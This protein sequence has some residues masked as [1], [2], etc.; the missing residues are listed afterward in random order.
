MAVKVGFI[1]FGEV[2]SIFSK[3]MRENG[4]DVAAYDILLTRSG[5]R[6]TLSNRVRA[7][8]I[9]FGSL[10]EVIAHA[11]YVL[12]TVTTQVAR[13]AAKECTALLRP[14]QILVDLN[15]TAP[16]IKVEIGE[17]LKAAGIDFVEGA[18][19]GAV[20]ATGIKTRILTGGEK[21][22]EVAE[23]FTRFGL[24][25]S[26]YDPQIGKA[27]MFKMLRSIFSKGLEALIIELLVAGKRAGI[28]KDLWKDVSEFMTRNPFEQVA[29]NWVQSHAVAHERRYFEIVQVRE[30]MEEIRIEPVMTSGTEAFFKRSI[31][32]G[33]K[34]T[35]PEKPNTMDAVID[36]LEKQL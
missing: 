4:V 29:A 2:A 36:F 11:D 22:K 33:L 3:P 7:E 30:T 18:I 31:S 25:V 12:S 20:G 14:G 27:S 21:G 17:I 34:D 15:S 28:E 32:T 1:G 19:L 5:G 13:A 8:G 16:S 26:Y 10:P 35:F 24:N 9:Q 6:E 23:A